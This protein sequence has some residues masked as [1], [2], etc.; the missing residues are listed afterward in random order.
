[1]DPLNHILSDRRQN[2]IDELADK[3]LS[4]SDHLITEYALTCYLSKLEQMD[5][6]ELQLVLNHSKKG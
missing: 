3:F 6:E 4:M 1:M 2:L 5:D